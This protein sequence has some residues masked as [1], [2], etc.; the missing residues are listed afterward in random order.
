MVVSG[1]SLNMQL[2]DTMFY[3]TG[4]SLR[5]PV[6]NTI[7]ASCTPPPGSNKLELL[8]LGSVTTLKFFSRAI[9]LGDVLCTVF[10]YSWPKV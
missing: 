8:L 5:L 10:G 7:T 6:P 2:L 4:A 9:K 1:K 3:F